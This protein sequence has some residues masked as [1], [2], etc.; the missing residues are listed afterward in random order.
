MVAEREAKQKEQMQK[1]FS[2]AIYEIKNEMMGGRK[3]YRNNK[4]NNPQ[5]TGTAGGGRGG[6]PMHSNERKSNSKDPRD[7]R[8]KSQSKERGQAQSQSTPALSAAQP[9]QFVQVP[10]PPAAA[11]AQLQAITNME[12]KKQCIGNMIYPCIHQAYGDLYVGKITGMLLDEKV[13]NLDSLVTD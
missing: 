1:F 9:A 2:S 3:P 11:V 10:L 5:R 13:V 7:Q 4:R 12:E 8:T 6:K